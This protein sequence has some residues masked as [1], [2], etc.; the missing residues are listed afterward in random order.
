MLSKVKAKVRKEDASFAKGTTSPETVRRKVKEEREKRE[1][2][3]IREKG[4]GL[5]KG[6]TPRAREKGMGSDRATPAEEHTS[7]ATATKEAA[8]ER[9][10]SGVRAPKL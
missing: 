8:G 3:T 10:I 6:K 4:K 5:G 9:A 7:L 2:G 1:R